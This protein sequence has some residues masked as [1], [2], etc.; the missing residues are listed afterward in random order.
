MAQWNLFIQNG[1]IFQ[2][3]E[4]KEVTGEILDTY[5]PVRHLINNAAVNLDGEIDR[6]S[7]S[8]LEHSFRVNVT[9][10][11]Q[12]LREILPG[13]KRDD[14]GRVVN[15]TSGAPLECPHG[16]G[17]YAASKAAL[18]TLTVTAARELSSYNIKINLM[19]PGPC[20]TEMAPNA[21]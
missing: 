1:S 14:F 12:L 19:S 18:N 6:I 20:E 5:G 17:A 13:M 7:V 8:D 21:P 10:P 11:T 2:T 15:I 16:A 9:A 4:L 3:D